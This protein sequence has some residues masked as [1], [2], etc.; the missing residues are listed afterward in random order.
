MRMMIQL[1]SESEVD[2]L[3]SDLRE[4][5]QDCLYIYID[6][7]KY[8]LSNPNITVWADWNGKVAD[9]VVM[10]YHDGFQIYSREEDKNTHDILKLIQEYQPER[11]SGSEAIIQ[12]L[13]ILCKDQ[14]TSTFGVVFRRTKAQLYV[15]PTEKCCTFADLS[16]IPEIVDLLLSEKEF[17]DYYTRDELI[18]QLEDRYRTKMGR[19]M[20]IRESGKIVGH[21]ATFAETDDMAVVSGAVVD[22]AYRKT[23]YF[24]TLSNEFYDQICRIEQKDAYFFST[25][26]RHITLFNK[27]F[28]TCSSYGKL[29]KIK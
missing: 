2:K 1:V 4:N 6:L 14:Y 11:I 26:K 24:Y 3:L 5:V 23:D 22:K 13:E 18:E 15:T 21:V 19:S 28:M 7:A 27:Y 12:E 29:V 25:S 17:R 9:S 10:K 20:V 8:R 16:D